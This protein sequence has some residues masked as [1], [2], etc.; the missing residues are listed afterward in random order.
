MDNKVRILVVVDAQN[1]F[2][3]GGALPVP[4]SLSIIPAINELLASSLYSEIVFTK[5]WHP[6]K[7]TS[8]A[9]SH[10]VEP[11]TDLNGEMKWP[12]HCIEGTEGAMIHEDIT[13][14]VEDFLAHDETSDHYHSPISMVMY[15]GLDKNKEEY[16]PGEI[17]NDF[18]EDLPQ[19][20][21][22]DDK[23]PITKEDIVID[24]CGLALDYCVKNTALAFKEI[25][26]NVRVLMLATE[27]IAAESCH[28]AL[29]EM[30]EKGIEIVEEL[31]EEDTEE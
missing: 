18:C 25:I 13:I 31:E 12:V 19:D 21:E 20:Y 7:H 11:F 27:G 23:T 24:V 26:P 15:K 1:D 16:A 4:N 2:F 17:L 6:E 9:E 14:P 5:D 30:R 29:E 22:N 10:K 3:E 8:F 28:N